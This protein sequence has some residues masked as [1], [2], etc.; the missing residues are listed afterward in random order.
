[1]DVSRRRRRRGAVVMFAVGF[2]F[3]LFVVFLA[4]IVWS[5]E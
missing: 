3:V 1:V 2:A 5:E 4:S